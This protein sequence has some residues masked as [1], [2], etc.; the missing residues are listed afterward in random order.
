[1]Y[2]F[3]NDDADDYHDGNNDTVVDKHVF[4]VIKD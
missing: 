3:I 2:T 1:M 4:S